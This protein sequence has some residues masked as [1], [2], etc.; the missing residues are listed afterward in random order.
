MWHSVN[1][2]VKGTVEEVVDRGGVIFDG[3]DAGNLHHNLCVFVVYMKG[4]ESV[5]RLSWVGD[6]ID[7]KTYTAECDEQMM[8]KSVTRWTFS[9]S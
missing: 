7:R 3:W 6:V 5:T 2:E 4:D 1:N 9:S 8:E